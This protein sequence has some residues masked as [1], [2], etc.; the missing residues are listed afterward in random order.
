MR[1]LTFAVSFPGRC[2]KLAE[3]ETAC[4]TQFA[5]PCRQARWGRRFRLP[6]R[7]RVNFEGFKV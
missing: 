3:G 2:E 6:G 5:N 1:S 4:P 7:P